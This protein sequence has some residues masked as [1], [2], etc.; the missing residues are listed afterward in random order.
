M[1]HLR[2]VYLGTVGMSKEGLRPLAVALG[3]ASVCPSLE[4]LHVCY[5]EDNEIDD[6]EEEVVKQLELELQ[7]A[8]GQHRRASRVK[9]EWD[10]FSM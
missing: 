6:L 5:G 1:R 4:A 10:P 2:V 8:R 9:F 3:D 7:R